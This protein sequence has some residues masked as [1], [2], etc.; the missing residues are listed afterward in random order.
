MGLRFA[1]TF[2]LVASIL[3]FAQPVATRQ[4]VGL[5]A[6]QIPPSGSPLPMREVES[7]RIEFTA[8]GK[9]SLIGRWGGQIA[10]YEVTTADTGHPVSLTRQIIEDREHLPPLVRLDQLEACVRKWDFGGAGVFSVRLL[11]GAMYNDVWV[12]DVM[13]DARIFRLRFPVADRSNP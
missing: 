8:R 6:G 4:L 1:H 9:A 10:F 11:G 12:I 5:G 13:Q 2:V 3:A 7:C